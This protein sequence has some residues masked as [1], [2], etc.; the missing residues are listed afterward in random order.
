MVIIWIQK[1]PRAKEIPELRRSSNKNKKFLFLK[2]DFLSM[3]N[4]KY[5]DDIERVKTPILKL[6]MILLYVIS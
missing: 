5:E 3:S 1:L 4:I 6:F 2:T